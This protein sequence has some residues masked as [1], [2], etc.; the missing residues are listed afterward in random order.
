MFPGVVPIALY[1][2][3]R[4]HTWNIKTT[5]AK[6]VQGLIWST[7]AIV[8]ANLLF[9]FALRYKKA[10]SV[11]AYQYLSPLATVIAA[12]YLLSEHPYKNFVIG[13]LL[14]CFGLYITEYFHPRH[15]MGRN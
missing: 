6:S 12:W 14:V 1:A 15:K 7:V 13:A 8:L 5:S 9:Y 3:T 10:G 11:G 2:V 4:L